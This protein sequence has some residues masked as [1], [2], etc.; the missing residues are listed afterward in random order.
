MEVKLVYWDL[1]RNNAKGGLC[2]EISP[3]FVQHTLLHIY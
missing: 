1:G 3:L 2:T